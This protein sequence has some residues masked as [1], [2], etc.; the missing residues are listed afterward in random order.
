M[1]R[2][3]TLDAIHLPSMNLAICWAWTRF[4][5]FVFFFYA[6]HEEGTLLPI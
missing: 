1:Q 6:L 5:R 2:I 3:G 4:V